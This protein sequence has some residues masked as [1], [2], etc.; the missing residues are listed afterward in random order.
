MNI[1]FLASDPKESVSYYVNTH[2][3]KILIEIAQMLSTAHYYY[4]PKYNSYFYYKPVMKNHPMNKWVRQNTANYNYAY[5]LYIALCE[6]YK[7][8][9]GRTHLSENY[10]DAL[11]YAPI[12]IPSSN[13][14]T[15]PPLCIKEDCILDN[16]IESYRMYYIQ[17][18]KHLAKW[19]N[20]DK[21]YWYY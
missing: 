12:S 14:I 3:N 1:F 2:V 13:K 18:K 5:K 7:Y 11:K 21:P 20:R 19:K 10:K 17:H 16:T 9:F 8:R 4:N 6:E 15:Q